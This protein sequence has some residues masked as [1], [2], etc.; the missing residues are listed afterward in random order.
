VSFPADNADISRRIVDRTSGNLI[1]SIGLDTSPRTAAVIGMSLG[2]PTATGAIPRL[3][4]EFAQ[5]KGSDFQVVRMEGLRTR[6]ASSASMRG[7]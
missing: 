6:R 7:F 2:R 3:V 1:A 5:A 4:S